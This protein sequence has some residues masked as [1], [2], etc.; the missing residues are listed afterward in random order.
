MTTGPAPTLRG[1]IVTLFLVITPVS[2]S[3]TGGRGLLAKSSPPPQLA[4]ASAMAAQATAVRRM[5]RRLNEPNGTSSFEEPI[6]L[7]LDLS[8]NTFCNPLNE[9]EVF[10]VLGSICIKKNGFK[11]PNLEFGGQIHPARRK[12]GPRKRVVDREVD[13]PGQSLKRL[14]VGEDRH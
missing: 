13:E 11:D 12:P 7:A 6:A 5:A 4:S 8:T 1:E 3:V 10:G 2:S 14:D 9:R